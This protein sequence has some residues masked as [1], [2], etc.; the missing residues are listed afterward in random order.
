MFINFNAAIVDYEGARGWNCNS[1]LLH[2]DL[3][4]DER[5]RRHNSYLHEMRVN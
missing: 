1:A 4:E 5:E 2:C 3:A